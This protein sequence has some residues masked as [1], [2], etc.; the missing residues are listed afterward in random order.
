MT[1]LLQGD[2][3]ALRA[4]RADDVPTL[5]QELYE[6]VAARSRADTR[7]WRPV[8]TDWE[9]SPYAVKKDRTDAM[10][11]SVVE[12]ASGDLAGTA[13]LWGID[14][15][16]RNAHIGLALRPAY[17]GRG[18]GTDAV[19]VLV[20][21]GFRTLGLHRLQIETLADN[22]GMLRAAQAAGF[23]VEGRLRESG[24]LDGRFLDD[25]NLGLLV[26]EY[27]G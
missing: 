25:V 13:L 15:H 20:R 12:L 14:A 3:V 7:A 1:A 19:R 16:N 27:T 6:D 23:T 11:F 10:P 8:A 2:K 26:S 5:H 24:W 21:Y 4:R 17:R 9:E 22:E 18:L